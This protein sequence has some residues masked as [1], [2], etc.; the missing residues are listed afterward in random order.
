[1]ELGEQLS[2]KFRSIGIYSILAWA[3]INAI[4][5]TLEVTVLNDAA[6]LNNSVLLVLWIISIVGLATMRKDGAAFA[7]FSL[8]YAFA[9]NAFNIIYFHP[10]ATLLNGTS[11]IIN[12]IAIAYMFRGILQ[13]K[14]R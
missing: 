11:A 2:S 8:T 1:L 14:F 4:F 13:N 9:F 12:G 5:M 3:V 10:T 6:D 7:T